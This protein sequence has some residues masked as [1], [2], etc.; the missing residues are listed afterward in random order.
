MTIEAVL[1]HIADGE[2]A[3]VLLR[4]VINPTMENIEK[5]LTN[6][7]DEILEPVPFGSSHYV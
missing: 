2:T 3:H 4:T 1:R 6:K 5:E 7:A